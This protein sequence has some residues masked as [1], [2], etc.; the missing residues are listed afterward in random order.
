MGSI[1]L[2]FR[3][4]CFCVGALSLCVPSIAKGQENDRNS[5]A[6][7]AAADSGKKSDQPGRYNLRVGPVEFS[8]HPSLATEFNDNILFSKNDR[9]SDFVFYPQF[10]VSGIWPVTQLNSVSLTLGVG[11]TRYVENTRLNRDSFYITPDSEL[12]WNFYVKDF[13]INIHER[14][15]YQESIYSALSYDQ[16]TEV[17]GSPYYNPNAA[18]AGATG[19]YAWN[20]GA[21]GGIYGANGFYNIYGSGRYARF[22]NTVGTT[23]TWDLKDLVLTFSYD[24]QNVIP[25]GADFEYA[26]LTSEQFYSSASFSLNPQVSTGVESRFGIHQRGGQDFNNSMS[27]GGGPFVNVQLTPYFRFGLG[28]GYE[29]YFYDQGNDNGML[30]V[31]GNVVHN[32]NQYLSHSLTL[33]RQNHLGLNANNLEATTVGYGAGWRVMRNVSLGTTLSATMAKE[34]GG[35]FQESFTYY[36]AGLSSGYQLT[37][38]WH[39]F[40]SYVYLLSDSDLA[41]RTAYVNRAMLGAG[42]SY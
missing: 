14:F 36:S 21:G 32:L 15:S 39:M 10:G 33:S 30:Y 17:G 20:G 35:A 37:Q 4:F 41:V 19:G 40:A 8:V 18:G 16:Y 25:N 26:D 31:Y 27:A 24:H 29:T 42:Y 34:F 7:E 11:V 38:R 2:A 3:R 6:G 12:A 28:G 5:M 22:E 23:V 9:K 1:G 13:R